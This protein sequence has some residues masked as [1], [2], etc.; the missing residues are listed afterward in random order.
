MKP[1]YRVYVLNTIPPDLKERIV[2]VHAAGILAMN[3]D[4]RSNPCRALHD[5]NG[6][7]RSDTIEKELVAPV[8]TC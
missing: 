1:K 2:A 6:A 3:G 8:L 7:A 4:I 5:L